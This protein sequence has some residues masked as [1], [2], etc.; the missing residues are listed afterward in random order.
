MRDLIY[1]VCLVQGTVYVSPRTRYDHRYDGVKENDSPLWALL[2]V[3]HQV[4]AEA[5]KALLG[6]NHFVLSCGRKSCGS[7][8]N[9]VAP[10]LSNAYNQ[11]GPFSLFALVHKNLR[12][13]SI[14]LDIRN[15]SGD[16][17]KVADQA[18]QW[19]RPY[20]PSEGQSMIHHNSFGLITTTW[21]SM[22][23]FFF[24]KRKFLQIDITN[25][26]CP[27]GC[28]R[29]S[30]EIAR[31]IGSAVRAKGMPDKL[32]ILGTKSVEERRLIKERI[33]AAIQFQDEE[34]DFGCIIV[35]K[36]SHCTRAKCPRLHLVDWKENLADEEINNDVFRS[37]DGGSVD[38]E[39]EGTVPSV[40]DST[41]M[42]FST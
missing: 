18:Y 16:A 3:S 15:L 35:F 40:L 26:F 11:L 38:E 27:L 2:K 10:G 9:N 29:Y 33:K 36:R 5:A 1:E 13:V 30:E 32:E 37:A 34:E 24:G 39:E 41:T 21:L 23:K 25:A 4:R 14:T 12:S 6:K 31:A 42:G 20:L 17:V 7:F 8:W 19:S 28:H 22:C